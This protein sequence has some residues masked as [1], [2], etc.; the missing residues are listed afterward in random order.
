[1]SEL[2]TAMS[3]ATTS[4]TLTLDGVDVQAYPG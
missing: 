3:N 4:F 2:K 1:M